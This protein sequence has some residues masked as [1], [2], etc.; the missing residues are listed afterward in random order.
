MIEYLL[1]NAMSVAATILASTS[2]AMLL[3]TRRN[4]RA[5]GYALNDRMVAAFLHA[6]GSSTVDKISESSATP[7]RHD[8]NQSLV[9][10][11]AKGIVERQDD[12]IRHPSFKL[13]EGA[14]VLI[15]P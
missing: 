8:I 11:C 12:S 7:H 3:Y 6:E 13:S 4:P 1:D 9:R 2:M 15:D 10:L 14:E 5:N